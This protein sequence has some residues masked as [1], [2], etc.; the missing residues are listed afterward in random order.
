[1]TVSADGAIPSLRAHDY[2][3]RDGRLQRRERQLRMAKAT[4]RPPRRQPPSPAT[5]RHADLDPD[6]YVP[7]RDEAGGIYT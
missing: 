4:I 5:A 7:H 6:R 3:L 1:M 2:E